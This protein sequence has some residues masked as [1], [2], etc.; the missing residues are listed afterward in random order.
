MSKNWHSEHCQRSSEMFWFE[1]QILL[2][3]HTDTQFS[4]PMVQKIIFSLGFIN[5]VTSQSMWT[6]QI[7]NSK[8][9]I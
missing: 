8:R 1:A 9:N 5:T 7:R 4:G 6:G 2:G 3:H